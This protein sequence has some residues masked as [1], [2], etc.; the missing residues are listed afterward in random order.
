RPGAPNPAITEG[1]QGGYISGGSWFLC[2]MLTYMAGTIHGVNTE[3]MQQWRIE[4]ELRDQP[5]FK[6]YLHTITGAPGGNLLYSWNSAYWFLR[7]R[8][9]ERLGVKG[10]DKMLLNV[11]KKLGVI[12]VGDHLLLKR[13]Q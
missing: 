5:S 13:E 7:Q 6:E 4:R 10:E 9:R 8:C 1:A 2:D 3:A 11:D 12:H